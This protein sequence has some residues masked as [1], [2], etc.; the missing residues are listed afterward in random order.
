[1]REVEV[2]FDDADFIDTL[3]AEIE[4]EYGRTIARIARLERIDFNSFHI[5]IVFSDFR[6]L[7][8]DVCVGSFSPHVFEPVVTIRGE[9]Y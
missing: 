3:I 5:S 9:Y 7:E 4:K 8:A 6:L 2:D 1:M